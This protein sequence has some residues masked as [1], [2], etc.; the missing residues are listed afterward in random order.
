MFF[1]VNPGRDV[2]SQWLTFGVTAMSF[3]ICCDRLS[4]PTSVRQFGFVIKKNHITESTHNC[5]MDHPSTMT[6]DQ[7]EKILNLMKSLNNSQSTR[8]E[9]YQEF[10]E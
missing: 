10:D 1:Y 9:L 7:N 6:V 8:V 3:S 5:S 2:C 4:Q